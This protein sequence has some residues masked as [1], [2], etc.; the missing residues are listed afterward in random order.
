LEMGRLVVCFVESG[1]VGGLLF[2]MNILVRM[3]PSIENM[4]NDD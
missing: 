3:L 2:L 4:G 1:M